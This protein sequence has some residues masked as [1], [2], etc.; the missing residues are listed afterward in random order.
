FTYGQPVL[1]PSLGHE[2]IVSQ[3]YQPALNDPAI[4]PAH[5]GGLSFEQAGAVGKLSHPLSRESSVEDEHDR[6]RRRLT[7]LPLQNPESAAAF[8]TGL[9]EGRQEQQAN[10]AITEGTKA[11][12]VASDNAVAGF[13]SAG[14]GR[15]AIVKLPVTGEAT[16][17]PPEEGVVKK[18]AKRVKPT[19]LATSSTQKPQLDHVYLDS[20]R[21]PVAGLFAGPPSP[22]SDSESEPDLDLEFA[23]GGAEG[24]KRYVYRRMHHFLRRPTVEEPQDGDSMTTVLQPYP[25][26]EDFFAKGEIPPRIRFRMDGSKASVAREGRIAVVVNSMGNGSSNHDWDFLNHWKDKD[27]ASE[28]LPVYGDSGSEVE[29]SDGF[30]EELE[31]EQREA[32][33]KA[34]QKRCPLA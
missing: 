10:G 6:K 23:G 33:E 31:E 1:S 13:E 29:M 2:T 19:A 3:A 30:V 25:L 11:G 18:V 9:A 5:I 22:A 12:G 8:D 17:K 21:R 20:R 24:E 34:T 4:R 16:T 28:P 14:H 26:N 15:V 7:L 27:N 32:A